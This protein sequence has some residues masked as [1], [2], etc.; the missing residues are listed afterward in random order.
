MFCIVTVVASWLAWELNYVGARRAMLA[1]VSKDGGSATTGA[2]MSALAARDGARYN[3]PIIPFWR[4]WLGDE[5][6]EIVRVPT[7][8]PKLL[9][10][11]AMLFPEAEI[12]KFEPERPLEPK[13]YRRVPRD[14]GDVK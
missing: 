4:Q 11:A 8:S 5:P 9:E 13:L 10:R 14:R 3:L 1:L 6:V 7:S 2:E 12:W